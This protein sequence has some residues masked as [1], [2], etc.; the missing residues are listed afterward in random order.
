LGIEASPTVAHRV[1]MTSTDR[2]SVSADRC[3]YHKG[4]SQTARLV[5]II[6]SGPGGPGSG[7]YACAPCREQRWLTPVADIPVADLVAEVA[8]GIAFRRTP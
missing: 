2:T 4:P 1:S 8:D 6:E 5:R 3:D 7:L